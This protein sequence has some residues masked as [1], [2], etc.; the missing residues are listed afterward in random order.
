MRS[1]P[2]TLPVAVVLSSCAE[3]PPE[4]EAGV[5]TVTQITLEQGVS[6]PSSCAP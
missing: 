1:L 5:R 4:R 6:L 3:P 2:T